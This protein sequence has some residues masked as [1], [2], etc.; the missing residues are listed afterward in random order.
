MGCGSLQSTT[1]MVIMERTTPDP[2]EEPSHGRAEGPAEHFIN[3]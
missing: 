1:Q 3:Q 2:A